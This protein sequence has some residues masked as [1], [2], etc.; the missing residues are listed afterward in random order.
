MDDSLNL[1]KTRPVVESK[2]ALKIV[3]FKGTPLFLEL[4]KRHENTSVM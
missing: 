2:K 4:D 3:V 1:S